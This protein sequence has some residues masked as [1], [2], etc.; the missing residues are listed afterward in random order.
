LA[1]LG[2]SRNGL[3]DRWHIADGTEKNPPKS[4]GCGI[5]AKPLGLTVGISRTAK[6][7]M[8]TVGSTI[9]RTATVGK[10]DAESLQNPPDLVNHF[11]HR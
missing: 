6:P 1:I 10:L 11:S 9:A 8:P 7:D 4:A 3:G 5:S 2:N